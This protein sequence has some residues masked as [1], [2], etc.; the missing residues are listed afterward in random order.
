MEAEI[1]PLQ[2]LTYISKYTHIH[3]GQHQ[4]TNHDSKNTYRSLH[5]QDLS[6]VTEAPASIR[7]HWAAVATCLTLPNCGGCWPVS[8]QKTRFE[9]KT[10]QRKHKG[11]HVQSN[12]PSQNVYIYIYYICCPPTKTASRL[13]MQ[14]TFPPL[15][16][17]F[18][19]DTLRYH[20]HTS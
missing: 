10:R 5:P 3:W 20:V 13:D 16:E 18:I 1:H 19:G 9:D 6:A 2:T 14:E 15:Q 7:G 11:I 17:C 4:R 8:L 12:L